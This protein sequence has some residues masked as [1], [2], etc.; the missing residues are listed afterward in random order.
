VVLFAVTELEVARDGWLDDWT[1]QQ[2]E[3]G[4]FTKVIE[5]ILATLCSSPTHPKIE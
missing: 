4:L 2:V 3:K 5:L 1:T